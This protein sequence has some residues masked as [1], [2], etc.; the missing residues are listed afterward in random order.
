MAAR[1]IG[2]KATSIGQARASVSQ[3]RRYRCAFGPYQE[4]SA[5][6]ALSCR[7]RHCEERSC[8]RVGKAK[9]AHHSAQC[10][11]RSKWW[12]RREE[13][14][15]PPYDYPQSSFALLAMTELFRRQNR[16]FD[17]AEADA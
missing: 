2:R 5:R 1:A 10:V 6:G 15:C 16:A 7:S 9:R 4:Y 17:F 11:S 14:L 12:A 3:S 8:R 13:R